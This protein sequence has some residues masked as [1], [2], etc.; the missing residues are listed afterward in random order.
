[1]VGDLS[2]S[3]HTYRPETAALGIDRAIS[4]FEGRWKL[5]ILFHLFGEIEV[6]RGGVSQQPARKPGGPS[7]PKAASAERHAVDFLPYRSS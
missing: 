5:V 1:M 7:A 6:V 4:I 3:N 2:V